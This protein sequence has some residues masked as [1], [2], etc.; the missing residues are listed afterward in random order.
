MRRAN[1]DAGRRP[2]I[3]MVTGSYFPETSGAGLQCRALIRACGDRAHFAVLTTALDPGLRARDEV[4]GVPVRRV[5]V[6][7]RSR[8]ARWLTLPWLI[9]SA[10]DLERGADVVHLHGYS[11]KSAV[12]SL[13]ARMLRKPVIVKL[14]S[15]GHDDPVAMRAKGSLLFGGYRRAD[16]FV[17]VS[18]RFEALYADAGLPPGKLQVIPNGVDLD[19]FR[20]ASPAE[21][22][23]LRRDLGL[24]VDG[25]LVL[26]V[27]FFSHEKCPDLLFD[28]WTDSFGASPASS[29][30]IVGASRSDYY[31][32]DSTM[33][34]RV[35]AD[36]VRLG[37][38][39]RLRLVE[40]TES[41]ELYYRAADVF[42]LPSKR[43]GLPN[44]LLEAMACG[45]PSIVSRL[46]GVTDSVISDGVDG[47]LVE[48][49]DR[50]ALASALRAALCDAERRA[51][52]GRAARQT[53]E[54]RF[55]LAVTADRYIHLY[56]ELSSCAASPER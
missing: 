9:A 40:H 46:P 47:V 39:D 45:L 49:G 12:V 6:N 53:V 51:R 41:I 31:E 33:A 20:P 21:R 8:V 7:A 11:E 14:T 25:L 28:A 30:V 48:P 36:A 50:E 27:G 10:L 24:P 34:A 43:E 38:Q 19:R 3:M 13:L 42:V 23:R 52:L 4:D 26:F 2:S 5:C 1:N 32:I 18:P 22:M 35:Q 16:R 56:E 15:V 29:L 44:A 37:C 54:A 17:A 55:S